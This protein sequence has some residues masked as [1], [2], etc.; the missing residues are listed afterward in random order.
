MTSTTHSTVATTHA[1]TSASSTIPP[2]VNAAAPN[3][4]NYGLVAVLVAMGA[5]F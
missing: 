2:A 3:G 1:T 4:V 5:I